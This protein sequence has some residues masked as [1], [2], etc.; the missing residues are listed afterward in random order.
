MCTPK[1]SSWSLQI[2]GP[3]YA[4]TCPALRLRLRCGPDIEGEGLGGCPGPLALTRC[5]ASRSRAGGRGERGEAA[6]ATGLNSWS[7]GR[8]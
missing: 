3:A 4:E 1:R 7:G 8:V 2:T 6:G 5:R